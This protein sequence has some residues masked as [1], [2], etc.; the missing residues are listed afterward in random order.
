M[1]YARFPKPA[2]QGIFL[3]ELSTATSVGDKQGY[4]FFETRKLIIKNNSEGFQNSAQDYASYL[5]SPEGRLRID[6]VFENLREFLHQPQANKSLFALDVGAGTGATAVRLA[7]LGFHVTLL[8]SSQAMLDIARLTAKKIGVT[9]RVT[10]VEGDAG[11]LTSLFSASFDVVLCHNVLEF[12]DDPTIV[13]RDASRLLR[14][15]SGVL[16]VVVRNQAGEVFKAAILAGNLAA[17]EANL[18]S[19]WGSEPLY[20]G[21]V[22]LFT[23]SGLQAMLNTV[24]LAVIAKRGVRVI[25]DY[26]P[27]RISRSDE[28][29]R[30]LDLE[31]MLSSRPEYAAVARYTHFLVRRTE[32]GA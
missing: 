16:S 3:E 19:E 22:R 12:V 2:F 20:G 32:S 25:A 27:E 29:P 1:A 8:D 15:A 31:K 13:L 11:H 6:L 14:D 9:N 30:I 10:F 28:Y 26:L 18:T 7:Q 24:S 21:K 5:E 4:F 17:A 23:P